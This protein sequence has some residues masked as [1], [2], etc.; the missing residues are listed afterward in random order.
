M[1]KYHQISTLLP[2]SVELYTFPSLALNNCMHSKQILHEKQCPS[3]ASHA[4]QG[5]QGSRQKHGGEALLLKIGPRGKY[6]NIFACF[7][8]EHSH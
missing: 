1:D 2:A 4:V 3:D 5:R 8:V 6:M 7:M